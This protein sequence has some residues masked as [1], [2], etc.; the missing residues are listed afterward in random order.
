ML[1]EVYIINIQHNI[2]RNTKFCMSC[3]KLFIQLLQNN[4]DI[5]VTGEQMSRA[6]EWK[7]RGDPVSIRQRS[8]ERVRTNGVTHGQRKRER[9]RERE[10]RAEGKA[11]GREQEGE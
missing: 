7:T 1:H 10:D 6:Y 9:E 2:I 11:A 8:I 3:S 4:N 5:A